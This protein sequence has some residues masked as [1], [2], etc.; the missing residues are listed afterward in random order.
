MIFDK[1]HR[2]PF[3]QAGFQC[4]LTNASVMVNCNGAVKTFSTAY[5]QE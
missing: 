1:E 5:S 4:L 3:S 2:E